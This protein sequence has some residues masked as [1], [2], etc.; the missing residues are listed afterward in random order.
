MKAVGVT[1]I[2]SFPF[3]TPPDPI[4]IK[5]SLKLLANL[6]CLQ[7]S[8]DYLDDYNEGD[9]TQLGKA[10]SQLPI[11]VRHAKMLL[12]AA[13]SGVLVSPIWQNPSF[14]FFRLLNIICFRIT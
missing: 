3:V 11:G 12:V 2:A 4:A 10:C 13:S 8:Q 5:S 1:R 14:H 6:G 9:I 7:K